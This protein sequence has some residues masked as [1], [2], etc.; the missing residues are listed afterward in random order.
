MDRD[1]HPLKTQE[2]E[3]WYTALH[4]EQLRQGSPEFYHGRLE[5]HA[6]TL[7]RLGVIDEEEYRD[8]VEQ[9]QAAYSDIVEQISEGE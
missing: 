5:A 2:L 1:L 4:N 6:E 7:Y 3:L 8:L 9:A